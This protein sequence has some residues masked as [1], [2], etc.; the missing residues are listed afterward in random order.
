MG[1][2]APSGKTTWSL[3]PRGTRGWEK[4]RPPSRKSDH[5]RS[6]GGKRHGLFHPLPCNHLRAGDA[7]QRETLHFRLEIEEKEIFLSV[8]PNIA[9]KE[10]AKNSLDLM[11]NHFKAQYSNVP[12]DY[13]IYDSGNLNQVRNF[14]VSSNI[15]IMIINIDAFRKVADD[16]TKE[17]KAN[18]IHRYH[19]RMLGKPIDFIAS[20]RPVV[21]IDEPQSVDNT[22]KAK[23]ALGYL[24]P[25][26]T[27]R[28]S[29]THRKKDRYCM[30]YKLDSVDA[31]DQKLVK[32]IVVAG[33][34]VE[35]SHNKP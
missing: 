22:D 1:L 32:Q 14:A 12:F 28:Y 31:Y 18:I 24:D 29:A 25:L 21:I 17:S 19:D 13:F 10:G 11:S 20:C 26:C 34:G 15:Q 23:E 16:P 8:A 35:N 7:V 3:H 4:A 6:E 9:I 30:M 5:R 33:G 2:P 27:L